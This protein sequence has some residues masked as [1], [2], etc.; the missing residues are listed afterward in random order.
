MRNEYDL[1]QPHVYCNRLFVHE[2]GPQR[3]GIGRGVDNRFS[4]LSQAA[5]DAKRQAAFEKCLA[6]WMVK[7]N[8]SIAAAT[9][10]LARLQLLQP[11]INYETLPHDA[12]TL[13]QV[14][15]WK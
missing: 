11:K 5:E 7:W 8:I 2:S 3:A 14:F 6:G 4:D 15:M 9:D 13:V 1:K 12:R 10:L